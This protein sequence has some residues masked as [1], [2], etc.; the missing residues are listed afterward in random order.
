M[1]PN[2]SPD[3]SLALF[4]PETGIIDSH[5]FMESL[6]KDI[7]ES[8]A[9]SVVPS[10]HVVRVDPYDKQPGWAVQTV[11]K[12]SEPCVL[13]TRTLINSTGLSGPFILN[14]FLSR[15]NP[16]H[17]LLSMYYAKGSYASYHDPGVSSVRHLIYPVPEVGT[18][19]HGFT[20]LGTHLTLDLS[21]NI[22]FGPDIEWIT[23]PGEGEFTED[24][25]A[26]DFW[27]S[28]LVA[29]E[30]NIPSMYEAIK[31]YLPNITLVG[32][33]PD[34]CGIRPKLAPPDAGFQDFQIRTDWSCGDKKG[35]RMISL[36]GIE[37]PGLTSSLAIAE[38]VV[39]EIMQ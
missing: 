5:S 28:Y 12:N 26:V 29:S 27:A 6:E 8:G 10:T 30:T 3:I 7:E 31:S 22:R 17:P 21:G 19:V 34:Y 38:M 24:E 15:M 9:G 32:L 33:R 25:T 39:E 18:N 20:G 23:P 36:L 37:S 16:P 4:S 14:S 2:L 11:N 35:G 13:L 1:E